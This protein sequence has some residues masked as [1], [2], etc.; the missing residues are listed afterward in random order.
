MPNLYI[1]KLHVEDY[2]CLRNVDIKLS[3]LHALV[4][5]NDSGKSTL[6]RAMR[7]GVQL[8][9]GFVHV[10]PQDGNWLPFDPGPLGDSLQLDLRMDG[11]RFTYRLQKHQSS[12][13][14]E[15]LIETEEFGNEEVIEEARRVIHKAG[16]LHAGAL[17]SYREHRFG[18]LSGHLKRG[19]RLLHLDPDAMRAPS[20]LIPDTDQIQLQNESGFGLPAVYDNILNRGDDTFRQ[21][22]EDVRRLFPT[23][24]NMRL[25]VTDPSTKVLEAELRTGQR[26]PATYMSDGLLYYLAFAAL[27]AMAPP[28]ILLVEEIENGL[29]PAR[30]HEVMGI[31]REISKETQVVIATHSPLVINEMQG[32]EVSVVTRRP[33]EGTR[34]T[35]MRDTANF[36]ERSKVYALGELW[37][38]YANGVDEAALLADE[39]AS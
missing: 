13:F 1:E 37:L 2:G 28:A 4:G 18:H 16:L 19:T 36:K 26:V 11:G 32:D 30:I 17:T 27:R 7:L 23:V 33:K 15:Q 3:R 5:P 31:M 34:V 22:V 14:R 6:L 20:Q 29:H 39:E 10:S 12:D 38:S 21:I 8:A 25:K 24:R 35:L 9:G